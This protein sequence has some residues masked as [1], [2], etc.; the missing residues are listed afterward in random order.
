MKSL[1]LLL[2]TLLTYS[3]SFA[4][5]DET[6]GKHHGITDK[7]MW[8]TVKIANEQMRQQ[9]YYNA[10]DTYHKVYDSLPNNEYILFKMAHAYYKGRDYKNAEKYFL[11]LVTKH[12]KTKYG[13]AWFELGETFKYNGKYAAA[14]KAF[15]KFRR[16][17]DKTS[18]EIKQAKKWAKNAKN[19]CQY[20]MIA[21]QKDTLFFNTEVLPVEV[22]SGYTD[23]S[24]TAVGTDT[25]Y[26]ASL[27][28][29]SVVHYHKGEDGIFNVNIYQSVRNEDAT[30][31]TAEMKE[32]LNE[33]FDHVANGVFGPDN[34]FYYT[35][36]YQNPH[37]EFICSIFT[38][39]VLADGSFDKREKKIKGKINKGHYT[40]TQPTFGKFYKRKGKKKTW[41]DVM[42]F[43]SNRPGGVGGM[44]I[45]YSILNKGKFGTPINCKKTINTVR[46]EIT[47]YY[48]QK[49]GVLYFSSNYK[50][51]LGGF[52]IFYSKGK[53]KR[54]RKAQN[55]GM[56]F[57]SS[58]D[59]T[60]YVPS[61][62][63]LAN[64]NN[65]GYLVSNRPGGHALASETCCDDIYRY[66]SYVPDSTTIDL[67][68]TE[69]KPKKAFAQ[70]LVDTLALASIDSTTN[71]LV[72]TT[73]I[74]TTHLN[75]ISTVVE[76]KLDSVNLG[77]VRV[78]YLKKYVYKKMMKN[79]STLTPASFEELVTWVDVTDTAGRTSV[80]F[81][82]NK[83]YVLLVEKEGFHD[84]IIDLD[85][86]KNKARFGFKHIVVDTVTIDK[87]IEKVEVK[88]S[89]T[90]SVIAEDLE[91]K[92][93]FILEN[94]YF[95]YNMS[96]VKKEA[97]ESLDLLYN[98]LAKNKGVKIELSGHTDSRG[99]EGYNLELS[100][101]R[102]ESVRDIMIERGIAPNRITA[103]GYGESI[104]IAP[105]E[106][107]DGS[108]NPKG[109]RLNRRTEITILA[110]KK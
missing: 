48:N 8:H 108:D 88:Q 4:Q 3:Q 64:K 24:P 75:G 52:D 13:M 25:L 59:D 40:S 60:Y 12:K 7:T 76:N 27:R 21:S 92:Q 39:K 67:L 45:W 96:T 57:N 73:S 78:G 50:Y 87:P 30:W 35:K 86:T 93:T 34:T 32:E 61:L 49:T 62:D 105:N 79:D 72:D 28:K 110:N 56:P 26:F 55:M 53:L 69:L 81:L 41:Y 37:N 42:Y 18:L 15:S 63:I 19:Y 11:E 98:F 20:A 44:D 14:Q 65:F 71:T 66:E 94:M 1:L 36:C 109:R 33:E 9:S 43:A 51:G 54:F 17:K 89:L 85:E 101:D 77:G 2:I 99:N 82:A 23:F 83:D 104:P 80:A 91:K 29:D 5:Q 95:E 58:Y 74:P 31:T 90:A 103:K 46:D 6:E 16:V 38:R 106:K 102:A 10:V 84:T 97:K 47:P 68:F 70:V 22:N 100:Q 107:A